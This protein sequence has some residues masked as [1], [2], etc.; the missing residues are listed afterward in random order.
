MGCRGGAA[1]ARRRQEGDDPM[2]ANPLLHHILSD[3]RLTRGLGDAE[4]RVL[5]EWL[6]EQAEELM[7]VSGEREAASEVIW[8]CRR[9]R[10]LAHFVRLW[11]QERTWGAAGQLAA[12]ERFAWPLPEADVDACELMQAIVSWEGDQFWQQR[13]S[14]AAA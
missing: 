8:L 10:A 3:E 2:V 13:R 9:C 11:C 4:A 12:A 14:S 6:V 5:I 1:F 7:R